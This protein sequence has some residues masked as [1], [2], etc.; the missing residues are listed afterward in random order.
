MTKCGWENKLTDRF[1]FSDMGVDG[2]CLHQEYFPRHS[3]QSLRE[4]W[5]PEQ[6]TQPEV[7]VTPGA[8]NGTGGCGDSFTVTSPSVGFKTFTEASCPPSRCRHSQGTAPR[9]AGWVIRAASK[10]G[11]AQTA[12]EPVSLRV[13][14]VC[15]VN[16]NRQIIYE[17]SFFF[18]KPFFFL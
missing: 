6:A 3:G 15:Y 13:S 8:E 14:P 18:L 17:T 2:G 7:T 11:H 16:Q 1:P 5:D 12:A 4:P 9:G 10:A